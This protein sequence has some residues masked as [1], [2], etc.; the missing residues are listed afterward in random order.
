[1]EAIIKELEKLSVR[2][3]GSKEE[4][5]AAFVGVRKKAL[6]IG[7]K[8]DLERSAENYEKLDSQFGPELPAI[9]IS[10]KEGLGLEKLRKEI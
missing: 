8:G 3:I 6:I 5:E 7:N 9:L 2:P 4:E 10:A 1:M